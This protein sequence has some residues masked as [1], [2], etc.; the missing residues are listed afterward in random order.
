MRRRADVRGGSRA[1]KAAASGSA[2]R[3]GRCLKEAE[4]CIR[5]GERTQAGQLLDQLRDAPIP[6]AETLGVYGRL[7]QDSGRSA[8]AVSVLQRVVRLAPNKA[9]AWCNL[10][11]ALQ[12]TENERAAYQAY[13]RA[14]AL[15]ATCWEAL[16]NLGNLIEARGEY[17]RA[18]M[19]Q[20]LCLKIKPEYAAGWAALARILARACRYEEAIVCF[21]TSLRIAPSAG[22]Y[23]N[24]AQTLLLKKKFP[25][26]LAMARQAIALDAGFSPAYEQAGK[27]LIAMD[28]IVGSKQVY[29]AALALDPANTDAIEGIAWAAGMLCETEEAVRWY[30]RAMETKPTCVNAHSSLL[31]ALCANAATTPER[32]IEAHRGWAQMHVSRVSRRSHWPQPGDGERRLRVGF[33]SGD[34]CDHPVRFF[35]TPILRGLDRA[36]FDVVCYSNTRF[37]DSATQQLRSLAGEWHD[38]VQTGDDELAALID[39]H[40]IDILVDLSGHTRYNRLPLFARKPAPVQVS[41]LGY[42]GTTGLDEIDYWITDWTVHPAD[43][44]ERTTEKIWRLSRCWV[45]YEPPADIPEARPREEGNPFTFAVFNSLQKLGEPSAR[46]WARALDAVP[47]SRLLIKSQGLDH[48]AE[49]EVMTRRLAQ[50]GISSDRVTLL[51]RIPSRR[52]FFQLF[53]KADVALDTTPW[54]GGTTTAETLWMGVPV[55]TL[56]GALM[57]SRMSASMLHSVGLDDLIARDEQEFGRIAAEL[58]GDGERRARLR[59]E[60]RGRVAASPLGDGPD[61]AQAMGDA[62]REMW[63]LW[64]RKENKRRADRVEDTSPSLVGETV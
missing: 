43:T 50:A 29:E 57:P 24:L 44:A 3:I 11:T 20:R 15:D 64:C 34:F 13:Q 30:V 2:Q 26:A 27:A 5:R 36:R 4:A 42:L 25:L 10:G 60:L 19:T 18:E 58:A 63:R 52:E 17:A 53:G 33:V 9:G 51:G 28:H 54:S 7:L 45:A 49:R 55:I 37:S 8:E 21:E 61:L 47:G 31:F 16:F 62:F 46:L 40:R 6:D 39:D 23:C 35:I 59:L 56:P 38:I 12:A 48:P 41:Y 32:L 22:A 1:N 14:I